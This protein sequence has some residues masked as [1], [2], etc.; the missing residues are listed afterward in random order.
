MDK[1]YNKIAY[2]CTPMINANSHGWVIELPQDV[3]VKWNGISEG[4]DGESVNNIE[5]VSGENYNGFQLATKDSPG[6]GAISFLLNVFVKTS[7]KHY[8]VVTGQPNFM[9]QDASPITTLIRSDF[10]DYQE[11]TTAWKINAKDKEVVFPKGMPIAFIYIYPKN[12]IEHT[13]VSIQ[14]VTNK[15]NKNSILYLKKRSKHFQENGIYKFPQ[16]YK[17]GIGPN[18][19]KFLKSPLKISVKP[20][21]NIF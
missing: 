3:V 9:F 5:I 16:F 20:P 1:T 12:L 14:P 13:N 11:L 15:I 7:K 10:Y 2:L 4:L 18:G 8:L 17:N 6:A 21:T 19:E